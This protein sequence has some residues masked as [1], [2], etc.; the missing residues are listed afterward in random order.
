MDIDKNK[1][2]GCG[3]CIPWCTMGVIYIGDDGKAEVNSDECVECSNCYRTLHSEGFN[4]AIVRSIRRALGAVNLTYN[5]P[6]DRCPV[7]AMVP[8][9]L[10]WPRTLRRAFSDPIA[11]HELTGVAGRGTEE[12]K[13]NDVTGRLGPGDVGFVVELGRPGIGAR[14][15]DFEKMATALAKVGVTFEPMNPL[16]ALMSDKST[17]KIREDVLDE[18]VMSAIIEL[19]TTQDKIPAVLQ[20]IDRVQRDL[21]TVASVGVASK[22]NP[23][24][25]VPHEVVVRE[26][27]YKLSYN[28]KTNLG[29][30]RPL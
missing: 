7:G 18:K 29:L 5:Q 20:A 24:G 15:R 26:L 2:V 22:C 11:P 9:K 25:S 17:G 13:T 21:P 19:K 6:I 3:N 28:G 23:D 30:G 10:E 27:G 8:P 14:F 16:T 12:I 4:P 1:C